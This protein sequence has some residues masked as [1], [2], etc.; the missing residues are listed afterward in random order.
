MRVIIQRVSEA[1]VTID[2]K[3]AG[4]INTGLLVL[5]GF[6]NNDTSEDLEW[7]ANKVVNMRIFND[8]VDK[9]NLSVMDINGEVLVVSQFTLFADTKKGNRPGFIRAAK[10]ELSIPLYEA[11]KKLLSAMLGKVIESGLFG[12]DMKVELINNGP[13][14][15][16]IDSKQKE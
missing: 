12:A 9:M 2:G 8:N 13:V 7:T 11:F 3:I 16:F 14:T 15:I 4:K 5:C 10:P 6:E 1:S